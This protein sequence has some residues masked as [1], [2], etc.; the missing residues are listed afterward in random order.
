MKKNVNSKNKPKIVI[1]E[2]HKERIAHDHFQEL[3][4]KLK[5]HGKISIRNKKPLTSSILRGKDLLI[6]GGPEHPWIFGRGGDK[7]DPKEVRA[8]ERFVST[9]GSLLMMGD[10]L[11]SAEEM[12]K[13]TERYGITF[14]SD[15]LKDVIISSENI[16]SHSITKDLNQISLGSFLGSGG[17]YLNVKDPAI[18][19]AEHEGRPI[20]A[21]SECDGGRVIV[22]SN[23]SV[24]SNKF[25]DSEDNPTLLKNIIAFLT[26]TMA[27]TEEISDAEKEPAEKVD[28]L[29]E[30]PHLPST[31]V[32]VKKSMPEEVVKQKAEKPIVVEIPLK[33]K[34]EEV[35]TVEPL[36]I[37]LVHPVSE[38]KIWLQVDPENKGEGVEL[39]FN[40]T[41]H[42][43]QFGHSIPPISYEEG[44]VEY[45]RSLRQPGD[46]PW[47]SDLPFTEAEPWS[48]A[49]YLRRF[50]Y[51]LT[52][53]RISFFMDSEIAE[54]LNPSV[55]YSWS[56][57]VMAQKHKPFENQMPLQFSDGQIMGRWFPVAFQ[58]SHSAFAGALYHSKQRF[59]FQSIESWIIRDEEENKEAPL[60]LLSFWNKVDFST[61]LKALGQKGIPILVERNKGVLPDKIAPQMWFKPI[62]SWKKEKNLDIIQ[63]MSL[64]MDLL[65]IKGS[66]QH[67]DKDLP[68][69]N[70]G[71]FYLGY[72][73]TKTNRRK[74]FV[75]MIP[76][77]VVGAGDQETI[78][79]DYKIIKNQWADTIDALDLIASVKIARDYGLLH[80]VDE[81]SKSLPLQKTPYPL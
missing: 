4:G 52:H 44:T 34:K 36:E 55:A 63:I 11:A 31:K 54:R 13:V 9:G 1:D 16:T 33:P 3:K 68:S 78:E 27:E 64:E 53:G 75:A 77:F 18:T 2:S 76:P 62:E 12:S 30:S 17:N 19:L 80:E 22:L 69:E 49:K 61:L 46:D 60:P 37:K 45:V 71:W 20:I 38:H 24:F 43:Q 29:V 50:L 39:T 23:L 47:T 35:I 6:I 67:K 65:F 15:L 70:Q 21:Y 57:I 66:S 79:S 72:T 7:W 40:F 51:H 26:S 73:V 28:L 10:G 8:I 56:G 14:S 81:V 42:I 25:I 32:V 48:P 74:E 59:L 5:A 41:D 58:T